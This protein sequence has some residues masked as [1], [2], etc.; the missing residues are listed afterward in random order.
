[1]LNKSKLYSIAL[2]SAAI[3]LI[4]VCIA[5]AAP[6]AYI[7]TNDFGG[8][9]SVI[10]T[11]TNKVTTTV[12]VGISPYGVA[13]TPD[14]TKVYVANYFDPN[15]TVSIINTSTNI[16]TATV[17]VGEYPDFTNFLIKNYSMK[18]YVIDPTLRHRPS[19]EKFAK[20]NSGVSFLPFALGSKTES[21]TFYESQ[22]NVSGSLQ[23]EHVNVQNDP[24]KTYEVQV[25]TMRDL[26][27]RIGNHQISLMKIDI[28]G[29][30][31][32]F[33][34]SLSKEDLEQVDQIILEFHHGRALKK[35]TISDTRR[36]IKTVESFGMKSILF[37]GRDC[38]FYW[39]K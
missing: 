37:N 4:M 32:D 20:E 29:E 19:L 7:P 30:E 26:L 18:C 16:V 33:I 15:P 25:V 23:N 6:F 28:E 1:M 35:Y 17:G 24:I 5:G 36:A 22:T 3:I 2:V 8:T 31:Y 34:K 13:V 14:G 21:R 11:A 10:D 9:V 12:P 27:T 39:K 38:L